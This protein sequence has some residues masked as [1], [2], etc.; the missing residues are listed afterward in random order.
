VGTLL[1]L[2]SLL[3][4]ICHVIRH[5][6]VTV[7]TLDTLHSV[8]NKRKINSMKTM[9]VVSALLF[10]LLVPLTLAKNQQSSY[11]SDLTISEDLSDS[12][13]SE[14][15]SYINDLRDLNDCHLKLVCAASRSK[16][17]N[18]S[19]ASFMEGF[20]KVKKM[21]PALTLAASTPC[22]ILAPLCPHTSKVLLEELSSLGLVTPSTSP[23]HRRAA[24][25]RSRTHVRNTA[26][27]EQRRQNTAALGQR[28]QFRVR[29]PSRRPSLRRQGEGMPPIFTPDEAAFRGVCQNCDRRKTVC[30]VYSLG[31][32]AGCHGALMLAG[33]PGQI[34]CNVV[35]A[36]GSI[37]CMMNTVHCYMSSCGLVTLPKFDN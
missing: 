26:V 37:G 10:C 13:D 12:S 35:T 25:F 5:D 19:K 17:E 36:P 3:Q 11:S 7:E 2:D 14:D 15:G 28:R 27:L 4:E 22:S 18:I 8:T 16:D 29:R 33:V 30:T 9:R 23:R 21:R 6:T 34:A 32:F 20:R 1:L 31:T 24:D